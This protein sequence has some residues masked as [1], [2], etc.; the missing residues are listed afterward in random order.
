MYEST[1]GE[2]MTQ[3][4]LRYDSESNRETFKYN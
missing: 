2:K 1:K 3:A 4:Q